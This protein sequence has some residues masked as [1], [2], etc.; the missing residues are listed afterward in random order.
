MIE[1][2]NLTKQYDGFKAVDNLNFEVKPGKI[3]VLLGPNGAGK[4]TTIKSIANL[5]NFEGKIKICG[6]END[7][8]EAK[9]CFGYVP[10]TPIL[11]DLLTVDEHIDFI[12]NAYRIKN[13]Q[14]IAQKYLELFKIIEKR[15][16]IA[17][18][19][20]KGMTQKLSM[21]LALLIQPKAL[22]VDEPMVGLDPGSIEDVLNIFKQ[23]KK[24]GC[25]IL[26]S[27]HIID[28][29]NDIYDEAYIMNKG[30]I[31]KHVLKDEL[32]KETLKEYFFELTDGK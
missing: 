13:Y 21:L 15:K 29:V 19:L 20:S 16:S 17:K 8:I 7:T 11:Y 18:E 10:E 26:I 31:I 23:L 5:L 14:E 30:K 27:T 6:Y 3:T 12:G 24:E 28:I 1:V 32:E 25:A 4:S 9:K 2:I 22:L